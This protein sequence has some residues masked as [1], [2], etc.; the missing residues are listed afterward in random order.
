MNKKNCFKL[1]YKFWLDRN[2]NY[3]LSES[4]E[5]QPDIISLDSLKQLEHKINKHSEKTPHSDKL[6]TN[7]LSL[8]PR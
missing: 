1:L 4:R 8:L 6:A 5:E 7:L 2:F 3:Y